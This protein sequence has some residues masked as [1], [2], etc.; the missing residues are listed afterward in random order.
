MGR[1]KA[2][3]VVNSL[4]Q[5]GLLKKEFRKSKDKNYY[6]SNLYTLLNP[7]ENDYKKGGGSCGDP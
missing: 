7:K 1:S 2:K 5:K 3:Y 6:T 4:V